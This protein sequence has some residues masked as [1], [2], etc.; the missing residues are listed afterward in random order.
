MGHK[1]AS[2]IQLKQTWMGALSSTGTTGFHTHS[3]HPHQQAFVTP[4]TP[5]HSADYGVRKGHK[6]NQ[7]GDLNHGKQ[8]YEQLSVAEFPL[9]K[10]R[11]HRDEDYIK[12]LHAQIDRTRCLN[13]ENHS[14]SCELEAVKSLLEKSQTLSEVRDSLEPKE[15]RVFVAKTDALST[16]DVIRQ[17]TDLN[18]QICEM[19]THFR[20][21]LQNVKNPDPVTTQEPATGT[22]EDASWM[23]GKQLASFLSANLLVRRAASYTEPDPLLADVVLQIAIT[24]WCRFMISSWKPSDHSV[25]NFMKTLYSGIRQFG[26]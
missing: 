22:L 15:A 19:A 24:R 3:L 9:Q 20:N 23:L 14:L 11:R 13:D 8:A 5:S 6:Q 1:F 17:V 26:K 21:L 2:M 4:P 10:E 25:A 18:R 16:A 12:Q 7:Q